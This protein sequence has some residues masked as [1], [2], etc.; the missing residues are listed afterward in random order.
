MKLDSA[1]AQFA[2][3]PFQHAMR[4]VPARGHCTVLHPEQLRDV[5]AFEPPSIDEIEDELF[6]L[7]IKQQKLLPSP[8]S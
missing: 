5:L 3:P 1:G 7:F 8:K 2:A 4:I 6:D